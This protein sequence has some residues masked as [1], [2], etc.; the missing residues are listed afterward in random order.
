MVFNAVVN[1]SICSSSAQLKS[2]WH[3]TKAGLKYRKFNS[4]IPAALERGQPDWSMRPDVLD[5]YYYVSY[6]IRIF[7]QLNVIG[8]DHGYVLVLQAS[9]VA[10]ISGISSAVRGDGNITLNGS[11]SYDPHANPLTFTWFCRRSSETFPENDSLPVVDVPNGNSNASGGCYGF[12]PGRL[13][14]VE[15]ALVVHVDNMEE[16]QTYVF[17]LLVSNSMESSKAVHRFELKRK[18]FLIR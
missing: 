2:Y 6:I 12:G 9:P 16:G 8:H 3:V 15:N 1:H 7:P 14:S 13:S 4:F 10:N 11:Q 17:E 5:S 18:A